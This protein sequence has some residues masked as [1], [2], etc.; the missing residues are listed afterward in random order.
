[1]NATTHALSINPT[2]GE[3]VGS[4]PYESESQLDVA[5]DRT[6]AAFRTWRRQPVSQRAELL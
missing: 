1:M 4:Y 2:N 3:T 5:L 6:T